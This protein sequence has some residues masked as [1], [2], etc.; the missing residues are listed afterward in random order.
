[1]TWIDDAVDRGLSVLETGD[2][3]T[4][5][6]YLNET[7]ERMIQ[8][9]VPNPRRGLNKYQSRFMA[10]GSGGFTRSPGPT[11]DDI[12]EDVKVVIRRLE[13]WRERVM[14]PFSIAGKRSIENTNVNINQNV[15]SSASEATATVE[16]TMSQT[17]REVERCDLDEN[18][19]QAIKAAIAD[20]EAAKGGQPE[21][22]CEKASKLLDLVKKGSDAAKAVAPFVAQA[23]SLIA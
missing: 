7:T 8:E 17:V 13:E 20:L 18:V 15:V 3:K 11:D 6:R 19:I 12:R 14:D 2:R 16:I 10:F 23:L 22:I 1:M 4:M 9:E 5:N 21:T